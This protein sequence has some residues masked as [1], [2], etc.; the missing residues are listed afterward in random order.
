[1]FSKQY[2]STEV[3]DDQAK[4]KLTKEALV[5]HC[6]DENTSASEVKEIIKEDAKASYYHFLVRDLLDIG[7]KNE[8]LALTILQNDNLKATN[9]NEIGLIQ[10]SQKFPKVAQEVIKNY[11]YFLLQDI[12]NNSLIT[13]LK[14][15]PEYID[16]VI[17]TPELAEYLAR[18]AC[19]NSSEF[20][21]MFE[22]HLS[23][24]RWIL[25]QF[26]PEL[27]VKLLGLKD[28]QKFLI[29]AEHQQLL[30]SAS[31]FNK[32]SVNGIKKPTKGVVFSFFKIPSQQTSLDALANEGDLERFQ[33]VISHYKLI[34]QE[35]I[36]TNAALNN[37]ISSRNAK[38]VDYI[39]SN[40][41]VNAKEADALS[42]AVSCNSIEIITLLLEKDPELLK[43]LGE[44]D[45][46]F[47]I[48]SNEIELLQFLMNRCRLSVSSD[49]FN[50]AARC[51]YFDI[52]KHVIE[53]QGMDGLNL[54]EAIK[55]AEENNHSE[56]A[57]YLNNF[58]VTK[59]A[60]LT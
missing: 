10:F 7:N 42:N 49:R 12:S 15:N 14:N 6:L 22:K 60:V 59:S 34:N 5:K 57:K 2:Y 56:L 3:L 44:F 28:Y 38:L 31:G 58:V 45:I 24:T 33:T 39:Y 21:P 35:P 51:G 32:D 1:M 18:Y 9:R 40:F 20:F 41:P 16:Y 25:I 52:I 11:D 50:T 37:A 26:A 8:E 48:S 46:Y 17:E 53:Q 55:C 43:T 30:G 4:R 27:L 54:P 29:L 23:F 36:V 13:L 19:E 47:A